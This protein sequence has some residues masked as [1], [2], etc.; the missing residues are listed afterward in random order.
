MEF[1]IFWKAHYMDAWD[2]AKVASLDAPT[3]AK[4]DARYQMGDIV[5]VR[6][7]G[8]WATRG[9]DKESFVVVK[10]PG[11]AFDWD[12]MLA[13]YDTDNKKILRRRKWFGNRTKIPQ[14]ILNKI[15]SSDRVVSVTATQ[16]NNFLERKT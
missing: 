7:D 15:E 11:M 6:E 10:V 1:L 8:Y 5:E 13:L 2:A 12:K 16:V 3:R 14:N 4:Y 9:F